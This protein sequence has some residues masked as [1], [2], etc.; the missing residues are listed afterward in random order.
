MSICYNEQYMRSIPL[1][2]NKKTKDNGPTSIVPIGKG[3]S[4][5][6]MLIY[7][8]LVT[9]QHHASYLLL[10]RKADVVPWS[11]LPTLLFSSCFAACLHGGCQI[12]DPDETQT[13]TI[14][15]NI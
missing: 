6:L 12:E 1:E 2:K 3:G 9:R 15:N 8:G 10:K 11:F 5:N 13:T 4:V 7:F 14:I